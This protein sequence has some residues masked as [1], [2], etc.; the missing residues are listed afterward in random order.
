VVQGSTPLTTHPVILNLTYDP[1][2]IMCEGFLELRHSPPCAQSIGVQAEES[3]KQ[4]F[5][6]VPGC[7]AD[8]PC[9]W[10]SKWAATL[11]STAHDAMHLMPSDTMPAGRSH[12]S[13]AAG[14]PGVRNLAYLV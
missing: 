14:V 13:T 1:T 12:Y 5:A 11:Q 7:A 4:G 9:N 10:A 8:G 6:E 2:R 3:V